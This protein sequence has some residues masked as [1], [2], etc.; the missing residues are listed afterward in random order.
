MDLPLPPLELRMLVGPTEPSFFD[1]PTAAVVFPDV[2]AENYRRVLDFGCGCGRIA[3]QLIQQRPR[4]EHYRGIDLHRG[5]IDWCQRN[6]APAAPG[7]EFAH[8]DVHNIS[9]NPQGSAKTLPL[10][11]DAGSV[12]LLLSWSVFTHLVELQAEF[13]LDEVARVLSPRGIAI[14]TWF[15]FEKVDFPM[16]QDFQN[17]LF[18]NDT[19][20]TNATIFDRDWLRAG[21]RRRGLTP[22]RVIPPTLRGYQW[23]VWLTPSRSG[24]SDAEFPADLARIGRMAPPLLPESADVSRLGF[25]SED[26]QT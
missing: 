6:L 7:F 11:A 10:P 15:L 21:L 8:H 3:R 19:D 9:F 4:P 17:C 25:A 18:I 2:P 16:M 26:D 13:Y 12:D 1:N 22:Y 20:P 24:G 14:T 5:M 23:Q